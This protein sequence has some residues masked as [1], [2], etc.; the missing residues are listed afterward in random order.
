MV[1]FGKVDRIISIL[2]RFPVHP[3]AMNMLNEH[4]QDLDS[5]EKYI[6][7]VEMDN[8][9]LSIAYNQAK[10]MQ[11]MTSKLLIKTAIKNQPKEGFKLKQFLRDMGYYEAA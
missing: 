11:E 10:K 7:Q 3:T 1:D 4:F 6:S 9:Q 5:I 8:M 2:N